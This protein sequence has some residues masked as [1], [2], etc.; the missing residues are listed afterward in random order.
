MVLLEVLFRYCF[1]DGLAAVLWLLLERRL[2]VEVVAEPVAAEMMTMWLLQ[3]LYFSYPQKF[4]IITVQLCCPRSV[5][6]CL[7]GD[8][9]AGHGVICLQ[10]HL[11]ILH[12]L[13]CSHVC[14]TCWIQSDA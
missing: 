9:E 8:Q 5:R 12:K 6:K 7:H 1:V 3:R 13:Y 11:A 2:S 14:C 10:Q 4:H